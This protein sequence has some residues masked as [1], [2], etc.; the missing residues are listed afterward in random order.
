MK[1]GMGF[2]FDLGFNFQPP[3]YAFSIKP[4]LGKFG[5]KREKKLVTVATRSRIDLIS[6]FHIYA[7]TQIGKVIK[8]Q[9][10]SLCCL[11]AMGI[12]GQ[13][14]ENNPSPSINRVKRN[15]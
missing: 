5:K 7:Y 4:L 12:F 2:K 13:E 6:Q 14:V 10:Q 11:R 8:F 3:F 15:N 9:V 1:I